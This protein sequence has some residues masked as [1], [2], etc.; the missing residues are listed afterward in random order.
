M[1]TKK[2]G[3]GWAAATVAA[4]FCWG[5]VRTAAAGPIVFNFEAQTATAIPVSGVR[6]GALTSLTITQSG[7]TIDITRPHGKFDIVENILAQTKPASWGLK[8]LDPFA[9]PTKATPFV[10]DFSV[11][12]TN[13]S[14]MAGDYGD[15]RGDVLLLEAFS[16]SNGSGKLVAKATGTLPDGGTAFGFRTLQVSSTKG[17][18]SITL[19]G[20]T[21]YFPQSV[22]YDN[23]TVMPEL[24]PA[25]IIPEPSTI[26]L[27][28]A[29]LAL[30]LLVA[31]R[32]THVNKDSG[33]GRGS[34][35][36]RRDEH[37]G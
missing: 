32:R 36:N 37:G 26:A 1:V 20:G 23:L 19:I 34:H 10:I 5:M 24:S 21:R 25:S 13:V 30:M 8:S 16:G 9:Q 22:F 28:S 27:V 35:V 31:R 29:G 6:T 4:A 18:D 33:I 12:V 11:P 14:I 2:F 7:L 3:M 17:I 15:D